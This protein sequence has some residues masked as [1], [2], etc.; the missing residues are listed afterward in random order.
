MIK[1]DPICIT[2][3]LLPPLDLLIPYLEQIWRSGTITNGGEMET[4]FEKELCSFLN[5]DHISLVSSGTTALM[6][7]LKALNIQGEVIT[8]PFSHIS[9]AQSIIWNGLTPVFADIH[10]DDYNLDIESVEKAITSSTSAIL[11]VHVFGNPCDTDGFKALAKRK[12][13]KLIYDAAHCFGME[14]GDQSLCLEGDL[15]IL[16]FH[17]T[18]TFNTIEGGVVI[19]HDLKTKQLIDALKNNGID[20]NFE[21]VGF[22]FN[23]K[24]NEIQAAYG[25]VQLNQIEAA[26]LQRKKISDTYRKKLSLID[27]LHIISEKQTITYNYTY[28]PIFIDPERYGIC[29]DELYQ[30]LYQ[31]GVHCKKYFDPIIT[32]YKEFQKYKRDSLTVAENIA[33]N[34]LCIPIH[35]LLSDQD[36]DQ[37]ISILTTT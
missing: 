10:K 5:V 36:V 4:L 23:A 12:G 3:P 26:I 2:F 37:I 7:A 32:D 6:L 24:L 25:L 17:A 33:K 9:T 31:N 29:R 21:N 8:S 11:P 16:S 20:S 35:H 15:S 27:G 13:L 34:L 22:G 1:K 18:K 19:C 14:K 30:K 28:F